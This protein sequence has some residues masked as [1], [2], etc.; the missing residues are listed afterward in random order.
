M[1][2]TLYNANGFL[3][4]LVD[5]SFMLQA[6]WLKFGML[7]CFDM[8][9]DN[10]EPENGKNPQYPGKTG[11]TAVFPITKTCFNGKSISRVWLD[12]TGPFFLVAS[13]MP[14]GCPPTIKLR[15]YMSPF[16]KKRTCF[17]QKTI[18][19]NRMKGCVCVCPYTTHCCSIYA[20]HYSIW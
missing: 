9:K 13:L 8:G 16:E 5:Y 3:P 7:M 17:L 18:G 2:R 6:N 12:R 14:C 11:H 10:T 1:W 20:G 19:Q 4:L 15:K